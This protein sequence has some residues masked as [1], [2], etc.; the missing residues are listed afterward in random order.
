MTASKRHSKT[1]GFH[2]TIQGCEELAFIL[3]CADAGFVSCRYFADAIVYLSRRTR[4][5]GER[6]RQDRENEAIAH[7]RNIT[8]ETAIIR[9]LASY[10]VNTATRMAAYQSWRDCRI[11]CDDPNND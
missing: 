3:D 1:V 4:V 10:M 11:D 8:R 6:E 7:R 9:D 5:N 2:E